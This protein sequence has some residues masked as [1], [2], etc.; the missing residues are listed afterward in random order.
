MYHIQ[1]SVLS[2]PLRCAYISG[3]H[4]GLAPCPNIGLA[5]SCISKREYLPPWPSSPLLVYSRQA[6]PAHY[7]SACTGADRDEP[8]PAVAVVCVGAAGRRAGAVTGRMCAARGVVGVWREPGLPT[9]LSARNFRLPARVCR[10]LPVSRGSHCS[11]HSAR[12][13]IVAAV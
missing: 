13:F 6:V 12:A 9:G 3:V 11:R 7:C 4:Q 2:G 8:R 1:I 10:Y 5:T